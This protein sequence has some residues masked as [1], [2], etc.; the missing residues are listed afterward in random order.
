MRE[1]AKKLLAVAMAACFTVAIIGCENS[2][3]VQ[4]CCPSGQ[5]CKAGA[6]CPPAG[7]AKKD[8]CKRGAE[9]KCPPGCTKP[10]CKKA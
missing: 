6:K 10:C 1:F 3:S 5:Q 2:G 7:C 8:C 9:A 4:Q